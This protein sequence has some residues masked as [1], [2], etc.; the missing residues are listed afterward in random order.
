MDWAELVIPCY[1]G[2]AADT[3]GCSSSPLPEECLNHDWRAYNTMTRGQ[4]DK[5][6]PIRIR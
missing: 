4:D 2:V 6:L 3:D 5:K 1:A